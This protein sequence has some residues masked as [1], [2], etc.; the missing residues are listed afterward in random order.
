MISTPSSA[1]ARDDGFTLLELLVALAVLG[2]L[3]LVLFG[4]LRFGVQV[5]QRSEDALETANHLRNVEATLSRDLMRAYPLYISTAP[6]QAKIEFDG[7]MDSLTFLTPDDSV[8]GALDRVTIKKETMDDGA[9]VVRRSAL[10]L[11]SQSGV[12]DK[13]LLKR[14]RQ[15]RFSYFG[16]KAPGEP[17]V[18]RNEWRDKTKLPNLISIKIEFRDHFDGFWPGLVVAPRLSSD[19][20]CVFDALAKDCRGR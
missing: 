5:W 9:V 11:S 2:L 8:P 12:H 7:V 3:S 17:P 18:W 1:L 15:L 14:V 13:V 19:V 16:A 4:S 20:G 10:E 6:G